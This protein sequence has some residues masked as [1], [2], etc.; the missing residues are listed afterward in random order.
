MGWPHESSTL[1]SAPHHAYA[2]AECLDCRQ[3]KRRMARDN[4]ND[5]LAFLAVARERSFTRAAVKLGVSQSTLSHTMRDLETRLG[6]RLLTR[7]TRSVAPTEAGERLMQSIAPRFAEI[8]AEVLAI[9]EFSDQPKGTIRITTIDY[10]ADTVLWPKLANFMPQYPDIKVQIMV[11]YGMSDIVAEQFDMGVRW[12]DQVAKDMIAVRIAP[13]VRS[14]VVA[15]PSYLARYAAPKTPQ[16]LM[17]HNCITLRLANGGLYAWELTDGTREL[18]VRVEGQNTF[19]GVYQMLNACLTGNGLA[20]VPEDL[21]K[22]HI[23]A[24]RL[25]YVMED[26]YPTFPGLHLYYPSRRQSSR[27]LSLVVGALRYRTT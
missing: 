8:D 19:N 6:V 5:L 3:L 17:R 10:A 24:G 23:E 20:F 25:R 16:D 13:D 27:A 1:P 26:W 12:G 11:E 7:T 4:I 18:Q 9:S 14:V 21:V 22:P 15:A 2:M